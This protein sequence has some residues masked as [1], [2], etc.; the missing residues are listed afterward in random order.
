MRLGEIASQ[1]KYWIDTNSK[2]LKFG[3]LNSIELGILR[4]F[5][6]SNSLKQKTKKVGAE[7]CFH[8][9]WATC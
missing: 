2:G 5:T 4:K 1:T 3:L 9:N 6:F 8:E 7:I